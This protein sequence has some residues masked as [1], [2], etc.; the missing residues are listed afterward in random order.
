MAEVNSDM[1]A[2]NQS[3]QIKV[4]ES[5]PTEYAALVAFYDHHTTKGEYTPIV[6]QLLEDISAV[7]H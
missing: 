4:V 2:M 5:Q 7:T 1:S 6:K 3:D